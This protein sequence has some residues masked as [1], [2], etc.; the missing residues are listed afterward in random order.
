M[1]RRL[2]PITVD[3][4]QD[5]P[6]R[7]RG[8]VFWELDP[9]RGRAAVEAGEAERQKEDWVSGLLLEWGS[10]GRI[11]YVDEAPA[12]YITY[13]PAQHVP[14]SLSFPTSPVAPDAVQLVTAALLPRYRG[15][16]LGRV[17]VQT[18]AKDLSRRGFRAIEAFGRSG[19]P[20]PGT[21][22]SRGTGSGGEGSAGG[23]ATGEAGSGEAGF[24]AADL[25]GGGFGGGFG[26]GGCMVPADYLR[27]VG[28]R[29]V[30]THPRSPRLRLD[31]RTAATWREDVEGA[32]ERLLGVGAA[33]PGLR[34]V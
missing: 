3:N 9:V 16:G 26:A 6:A 22:R 30:R 24:G 32:L 28:F 10:C 27:A 15:Q 4:L 14:G 12:G 31:L 13:A 25:G 23:A 7:C 11:L 20:W 29:T 34:P 21:E 5:L 17:L 2:V 33:A 18:A 8:C 1:G 19:S